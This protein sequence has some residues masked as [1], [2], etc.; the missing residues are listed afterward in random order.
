MIL[1]F[2]W[3]EIIN[4]ILGISYYAVI[5]SMCWPLCWSYCAWILVIF[6]KMIW[7]LLVLA[8][9]LRFLIIKTAGDS[10]YLSYKMLSALLRHHLSDWSS[11][12]PQDLM[13]SYLFVYLLL[14]Q[15]NMVSLPSHNNPRE[16]S[17]TEVTT[18]VLCTPVSKQSWTLRVLE[19]VFHEACTKTRKK[20][21][22]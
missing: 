6:Y 14:L 7:Y 22:L 2:V 17:S 16:S 9:L 21:F 13:I 18:L 10:K 3:K 20:M 5:I 8:L 12:F 11:Y 4:V 19:S 1:C 15:A